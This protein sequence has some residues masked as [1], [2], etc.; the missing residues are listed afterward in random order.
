V[1][2]Y[3]RGQLSWRE[4][5]ERPVNYFDD[6]TYW[7][8]FRYTPKANLTVAVGFRYFSLTRFRYDVRERV[9]D[10]RL[11]NYGPTCLFEWSMNR[12]TRLFITGWY[13]VQ[14]QSGGPSESVSNVA[15]SI[16]LG[17]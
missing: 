12:D 7:G 9:F 13:E 11:V 3:E 2:L 1:K 4:F 6:R 10:N 17:L 15:M 14:A 16:I 5:K 8:Q